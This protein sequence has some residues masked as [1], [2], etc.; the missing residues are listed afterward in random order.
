MSFVV[1]TRVKYSASV[2][3]EVM[4]L[5]NESLP[6]VKQQPGLSSVKFHKSHSGNETMMYWD[7]ES[8]EAHESCMASSEWNE[9]SPRWD[10]LFASGE[11]EFML[12]TYELVS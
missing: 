7:W 1:I 12:D 6:I 2:E 9:L 3:E 5:A 10:K 8:K 11:A 4:A